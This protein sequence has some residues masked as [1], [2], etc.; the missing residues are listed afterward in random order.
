MST[1]FLG[2][3]AVLVWRL[4]T[5][6]VNESDRFQRLAADERRAQLPLPARRGALLDTNGSPLAITVLYDAVWVNT[7]QVT[8]PEGVSQKLAP[9]VG[10]PAV[11]VKAL[12]AEGKGRPVMLKARLS[13]AVSERVRALKIPGVYME[14]APA[15]EYPDGSLAAQALGFVGSD[16]KGLGGVELSYDAELAGKPGAV[17]TETDTSGQEITLGRRVLTPATEGSDLVLTLDRYVQ[18]VAE[19]LLNEAVVTNKARG[20]LIIVMEP[21]TGNIIAAASNPTFSLTDDVLYRPEQAGLYK[22]TVVTD[23]YEPGSTM[24]LVTMASAIDEGLVSPGT[25]MLDNGTAVV[26]GSVIHNWDGAANGT[27]TMTQILIKSSNVGTQWVAG[28]LGQDRFYQRIESFGFGQLTG[29]RLPGETTGSVRTPKSD[30]WSRVDLATNAYGQGIAVTPVQMLTAIASLA[31]DGL[32]MQPRIVREVRNGAQ[33]SAVPP[34]PIRQTVSPRTARTLVQMMVEVANQEALLPMRIPGYQIALKTGT[35]DT[36][37]GTG[38]NLENTYA[39]VAAFLPAEDPKLAVLIRLDGPE[40]MYGGQTA[41]P[42]LKDLAKALFDYYRIPPS[43]PIPA[44]A[45]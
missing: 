37:T 40:K 3:A 15:R 38:Y 1:L 39:S 13:A 35:A 30:G 20:G 17:D 14:Q 44:R 23:Q 8:D 42:V 2:C 36:P 28:Q 41:V 45:R 18:R 32:M 16:F 25:T 22:S 10:M 21:S 11:D 4:F 34:T 27:I 24:K 33:P 31:N 9:V 12:I 29:I 43:L 6:Q 7:P 19:R 26:G 5:L